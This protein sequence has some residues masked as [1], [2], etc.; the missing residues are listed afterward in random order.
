MSGKLKELLNRAIA[1]ELQ[2]SIQY[3]WQSV[4]AKG[5][6]GEVIRDQIRKIAITE[7]THAESIAKRLVYLGERPTTKPSKITVGENAKEM[8]EIDKKAEEE[9]IE[10]YKEIIKTAVEEG[11]V[12][13]AKL[14]EDI[15]RDEEDHHEF[16]SS[17]LES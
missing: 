15:L 2:V 14:F 5:F 11:D 1:R 16:F 13:T 7:M 6:E 9:A 3:M 17:L 10:L 8:M 12:T 4:E